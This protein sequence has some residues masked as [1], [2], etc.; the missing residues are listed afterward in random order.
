MQIS[1]QH[2][3]FSV[4]AIFAAAYIILAIIGGVHGYS[5]VPF[6]DMWDDY[7]NFY[8]QL[9]NGNNSVWWNQVNEHRILLA[10]TLF[11]LDLTLFNGTGFFLVIII[12]ILA[13]FSFLGLFLYLNTILVG[14]ENNFLRKIVGLVILILV[15]SWIQKENFTRGDGC[16]FIQAQLGPLM[17]FYLLHKAKVSG[18]HARLAFFFAC[19][20]GIAAIGTLANGV[21]ALPLLTMLAAILQMGWR[22]IGILFLLSVSAIFIYFHNYITPS[23]HSSP[24][25]S[26]LHHPMAL[27]KY[28]LCYLGGPFYYITGH[29]STALIAG[30][31]FIIGTV[32]FVYQAIK[33][34]PKPSCQLALLT[35]IL[36]IIGT[37]V[38][39]GSGRLIFGLEQ[40]F[41]SRYMT[42][43][44]LAWSALL[45][46]Y[47]SILKVRTTQQFYFLVPLVFVPT[48][49]FHQQLTALSE[50]PELFERKIAALALDFGI[51]DQ[52]QIIF[53]YPKAE[54]AL[55]I[56]NDAIKR[57]LSIFNQPIFIDARATITKTDSL[58][59]ANQCLGYVDGSVVVD[60][61]PRYLRLN[62]WIYQPDLK[63]VPKAIRILNED[64]QVVGY[65]LTGQYRHDVKKA[66]HSKVETLGFKG[67]LLAKYAGKQVI[68]KGL[69]PECELKLAIPDK[70]QN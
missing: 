40:A 22:R 26:L 63:I 3:I 41:S 36:Y 13:G 6:Q 53:V 37:A 68:L 17:A 8:T 12:Y 4:F 34:C 27:L 18:E 10:R 62:G 67:Y 1:K 24:L 42:P 25:E 66:L 70:K 33:T 29:G 31:F 38:C 11:Y 58:Q 39:T 60:Q 21:L 55:K 30:L 47:A 16:L 48:L 7:V 20:L 44:L 50:P 43:V 69:Q 9:L 32:V 46:L 49:L 35:F 14:D 45:I 15:F 64:R 59:T 2:Y 56:A 23:Y 5:P 54:R 28:M 19:L 52:S 57:N 65:A 61:D 51:K